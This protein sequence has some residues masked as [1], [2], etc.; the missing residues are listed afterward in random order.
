MLGVIIFLETDSKGENLS[1]IDNKSS[2]QRSLS[3]I[4]E[5]GGRTLIGR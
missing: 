1:F 2:M 5:T 3:K 4:L